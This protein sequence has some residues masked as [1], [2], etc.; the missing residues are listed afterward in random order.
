MLAAV[1]DCA[2]PGLAVVSHRGPK[3]RLEGPACSLCEVAAVKDCAVTD[4]CLLVT[5]ERSYSL[6]P[7]DVML[8]TAMAG[9]LQCP[10]SATTL[11]RSCQSSHH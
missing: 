9:L 1:K 6:Q 10:L 8:C 3:S 7:L 4:S 2:T 5:N 11:W